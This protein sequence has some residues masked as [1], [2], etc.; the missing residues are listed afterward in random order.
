MV[1]INLR[2]PFIHRRG[3][4]QAEHAKIYKTESDLGKVDV[5]YS[6]TDRQPH[7]LNMSKY[8]DWANDPEASIAFNV[9]TDIIAGVGYYTE[10]PEKDKNGKDVDPNHKHK[11]VIDEY[12]ERVNLDEDLAEIVMTYLQKGFCP[13]ERLANYDLKVLQPESFYIWMN[14]RGYIYR[15]TQE[16]SR[17]A[18][19]AVWE[20]PRWKEQLK[21]QEALYPKTEFKQ[22]M[23]FEAKEPGNMSDIIVFYHRKT[24]NRPYGKSLSE[25]IGSLLDSRAE[26][27]VDMPKAIHRWAYPIPVVSTSRD[28]TTLQKAFVDRDV[29]E[30]VFIGNTNP[31]EVRMDTLGIDP[32]ARFI[33][34][35]E[36]IYY[37]IA[38]GLHAPLLL[39][40]KNATEASATVMMESIDRLV[41]GLQRYVKRRVEKYLFEPQ[42]GEPVPRLVWGQPKTGLEDITL[43]D[44]AQVMPFLTRNQREDLLKQFGI[45]LPDAE[46]DPLQPDMSQMQ[47]IQP[48]QKPTM[49]APTEAFLDKIADMT[50]SLN[51]VETNFHEHTIPLTK[52][53]RMGS[54]IIEV[55]LKR[56]YGKN[57]RVFET[58]RELEFKK[59][60]T[61]L[62]GMKGGKPTYKV[63][64]DS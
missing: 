59:W 24:P 23:G 9:L 19:I 43:T 8:E 45:Q 64:V 56:T 47:P 55:H 62:T 22:L 4:L 28:K 46:K 61:R 13:V 38:E 5:S 2:P 17:G 14:K 33:P 40:L 21:R 37:Q 52:A 30:A 63:T 26:M 44:V 53:M 60:I 58:A 39:Y 42:V 27:N 16:R 36:L 29:D 54:R 10:M 3:T 34:Y 48:F 51:V 35:I 32:Q 1:E 31:D 6:W 12:G 41:N 25:P 18:V 49:Q 7:P 50:T 20:E 15:Y 11:G 57:L